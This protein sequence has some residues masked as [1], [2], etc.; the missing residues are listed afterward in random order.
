MDIG[1]VIY[2]KNWDTICKGAR[3]DACAEHDT[4][5]P[6]GVCNE[7]NVPYQLYRLRMRR[8][9]SSLRSEISREKKKA[10]E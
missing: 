9:L 7:E 3:D 8:Y 6:T 4:Q 1:M 2:E 5:T 10:A